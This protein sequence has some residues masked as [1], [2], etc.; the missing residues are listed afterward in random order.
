M[1]E[2]MEQ[3]CCV[4][5]CQKLDDTQTETIK[6]IQQVF[7]DVAL[8]PTQIKEWYKRFKNGRESVESE[9]RSGRPSTSRNEEMKDEILKKCWKIVV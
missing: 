8:S 1:T 5:F 4:K 3:R 2:K 9:P 6:K 7:G